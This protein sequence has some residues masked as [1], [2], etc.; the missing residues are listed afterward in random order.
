MTIEPWLNKQ[1]SGQA[2]RLETNLKVGITFGGRSEEA[3][4]AALVSNF[5]L[6][7]DR[8]AARRKEGMI[9]YSPVIPSV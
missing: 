2:D 8:N 3:V 5:E 4:L 7:E 6:F 1:R 9:S